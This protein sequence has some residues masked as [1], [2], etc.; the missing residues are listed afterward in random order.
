ML[1][2]SCM[3][4][5]LLFKHGTSKLMPNSSIIKIMKDLNRM[6]HLS[7]EMY[8][9]ILVNAFDFWLV[10][11]NSFCMVFKWKINIYIYSYFSQLLLSQSMVMCLLEQVIRKRNKWHL[12]AFVFKLL[13]LNHSD[14]ISV[15][16]SKLF[17][18]SLSKVR[19]I[20][21]KN[22]ITRI[23]VNLQKAK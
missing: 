16:N 14:I 8:F 9:G 10:L 18:T 21:L 23:Y 1:F 13:K 12:K 15:V 4:L 17:M 5:I 11:W 6:I 7:L 22:Q 19:T 3:L 20:V 2:H